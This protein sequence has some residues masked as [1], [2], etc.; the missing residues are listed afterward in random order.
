MP[1]AFHD[2]KAIISRPKV[3]SRIRN[4]NSFHR[5]SAACSLGL[6]HIK[7]SLRREPKNAETALLM[8]TQ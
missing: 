5:G 1:Q 6:G 8:C 2:R 3:I 4:A 7:G